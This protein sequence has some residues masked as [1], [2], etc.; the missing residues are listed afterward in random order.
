MRLIFRR[1][2]SIKGIAFDQRLEHALV[3]SGD[4]RFRGVCL[5]LSFDLDNRFVGRRT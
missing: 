1:K 5:T 3:A 2:V 4:G